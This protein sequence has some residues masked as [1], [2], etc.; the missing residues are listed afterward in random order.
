MVKKKRDDATSSK[1]DQRVVES[2]RL[3]LN[4]APSSEF[5]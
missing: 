5:E 3:G 1:C 4:T 2:A